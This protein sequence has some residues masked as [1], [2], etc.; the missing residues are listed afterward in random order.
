MHIPE[1][2]WLKYKIADAQQFSWYDYDSFLII[3]ATNLN[4]CAMVINISG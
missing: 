1:H 2:T 3:H 4:V